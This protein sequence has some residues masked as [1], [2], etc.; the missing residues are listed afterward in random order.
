MGDDLF[1]RFT[2]LALVYPATLVSAKTLM[3]GSTAKEAGY[4]AASTRFFFY[5]L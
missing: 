3:G 5:I 1:S 2:Q 4:R